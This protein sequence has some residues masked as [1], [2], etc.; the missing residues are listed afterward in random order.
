MGV[1][2]VCIH[3]RVCGGHRNQH[4]NGIVPMVLN[5]FLKF[6]HS[7]IDLSIL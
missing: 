1:L 6:I 3:E 5:L 7:I 4:N 2:N